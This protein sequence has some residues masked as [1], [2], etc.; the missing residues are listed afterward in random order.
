MAL[1]LGAGGRAIPNL[2]GAAR[3]STKAMAMTSDGSYAAAV[4][5]A[6][7]K[8]AALLGGWFIKYPPAKN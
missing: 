1:A 8:T 4:D 7:K 5:D 6:M 3:S 2:G